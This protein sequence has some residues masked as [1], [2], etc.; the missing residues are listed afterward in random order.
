MKSSA[1]VGWK[2]QSITSVA[3]LKKNQSLAALK[4]KSCY[5][6]S[7]HSCSKQQVIDLVEDAGIPEE[8]LYH[9]KLDFGIDCS[10]YFQPVGPC[11][12]EMHI[13]L[14]SEDNRV[15][16]NAICS[17]NSGD[18]SMEYQNGVW[19]HARRAFVV[20]GADRVRYI[21]FLHGGT[22]YEPAPSDEYGNVDDAWVDIGVK[23]TGGS[24][25]V[26][27]PNPSLQTEDQQTG[28]MTTVR[29]DR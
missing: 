14:L 28:K 12:Y 13:T 17:E 8:I 4:P 9:S 22:S 27:L 2:V 3:S 18:L 20:G 25:L 7:Y 24:V 23:M 16:Q 29:P 26:S 1:G 11:K 21:K 19:G 6:A 5:K 15:V 10:E